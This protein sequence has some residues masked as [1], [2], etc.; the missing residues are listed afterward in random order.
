MVDVD[1]TSRC[2]SNETCES[3]GDDGGL[4]PVTLSATTGI[5]CAT[6]CDPCIVAKQFPKLS[7]VQAAERAYQHAEH[8]GLT[9]DEVAELAAPSANDGGLSL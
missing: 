1:D 7:W 9:L 8:L 4:V 2:P 5:F 3:C 6:M